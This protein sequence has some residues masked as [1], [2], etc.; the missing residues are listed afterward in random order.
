[1]TM[2]D[3]SRASNQQ[4]GIYVDEEGNVYQLAGRGR[5]EANR[6]RASLRT[7][8]TDLEVMLEASLKGGQANGEMQRRQAAPKG[9]RGRGRKKQALQ[10]GTANLSG[11]ARPEVPAAVERTLRL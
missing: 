5:D 8:K 3:R 7:E 6:G 11:R 9:S 10:D 1:M 2:A 4:E